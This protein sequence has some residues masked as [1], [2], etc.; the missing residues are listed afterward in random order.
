M[1]SKE[2]NGLKRYKH[3]IYFQKNIGLQPLYN[4]KNIYYKEYKNGK[5]REWKMFRSQGKWKIGFPL[6]KLQTVTRRLIGEEED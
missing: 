2:M 6:F 4:M 5:K 1:K 3:V